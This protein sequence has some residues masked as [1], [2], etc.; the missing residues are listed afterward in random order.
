MCEIPMMMR[1]KIN[2]IDEDQWWNKF[3]M[4]VMMIQEKNQ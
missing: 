3:P 1:K 4:N 2:Q